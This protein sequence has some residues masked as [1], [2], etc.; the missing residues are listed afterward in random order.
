MSATSV[1][2]TSSLLV[3]DTESERVFN[4]A[5]AIQ[6]GYQIEETKGWKRQLITI[7]KKKNMY[8]IEQ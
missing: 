4:Q 7:I 3:D 6:I 8:I 2:T 5:V 1:K